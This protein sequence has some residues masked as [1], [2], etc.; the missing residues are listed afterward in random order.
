[1]GSWIVSVLVRG[2]DGLLRWEDMGLTM[3][4]CSPSLLSLKMRRK[5]SCLFPYIHA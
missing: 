2:N 4:D 3:A 5:S 1:M